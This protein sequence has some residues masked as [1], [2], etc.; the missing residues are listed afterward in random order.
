MALLTLSQPIRHAH[1]VTPDKS[2]A[3][4]AL[5]PEVRQLSHERIEPHGRVG[6]ARGAVAV[7]AL[8]AGAHY[9]GRRHKRRVVRQATEREKQVLSFVDPATGS[10]VVIVGCMHFNP[11][12]IDKSR[13]ITRKLAQEGKLAAV[14]LETC[15]ERWDR[16]QNMQ[17]EGSPLRELLD[18]E[19]QAAAEEAAAANKPVLLG[20]QDFAEFGANAKKEADRAVADLLN[21]LDG[22][23]TTASKLGTG[24]WSLIDQRLKKNV[25]KETDEA[26][27]PLDLLD[28]ELLKGLPVTIVRYPLSVAL[29]A[30]LLLI[31]LISFFSLLLFLESS[32]LGLVADAISIFTEIILLRVLLGP[33]VKSRDSILAN[34]VSAACKEQ[35][36]PGRTVVAILGAAHCNGVRR[37][38]LESEAV[39]RQ[40]PV[41]VR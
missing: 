2:F 34:S 16:V 39:P 24:V 15:P 26:L 37:L 5:A 17:P 1:L 7:G 31:A 33:A 3:A 6:D 4:D 10:D 13:D 25:A 41:W 12:S 23:I 14:V 22:W 28:V 38:I 36:G 20:D 8:L 19:L 9:R 35:G 11:H 21:P 29:R 32:S 27:G 18:N 40:V 30:P